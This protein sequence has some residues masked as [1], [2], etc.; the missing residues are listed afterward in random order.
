MRHLL[1]VLAVV[2]C[3]LAGAADL[4]GQ[5]GRTVFEGKGN[6]WTCHAKTARGTALGPDLTDGEWLNVDGSL[7]S[8]RV[9]IRRGVPKPRKYPTPMPP[10][11]G[12]KLSGAEIDAVAA[13]VLSLQGR[14]GEHAVLRP[15]RTDRTV[16]IRR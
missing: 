7:D 15:D 1:S 10:M 14:P 9:L 6:C 3:T 11:G 5:Q 8:V 13:Y 2:G 4:N 12:A 16:L